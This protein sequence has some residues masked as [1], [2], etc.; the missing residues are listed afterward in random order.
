M[1]SDCL[2]DPDELAISVNSLDC[3]HPRDREL[4]SLI[5]RV[6]NTR[7]LFQPNVCNLSFPGDLSAVRSEVSAR[8]VD[9]KWTVIEAA[10]NK[11]ILKG[12]Y[13]HAAQLVTNH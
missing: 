6:R 9:C 1:L 10:G 7:N 3:G 13:P 4:V 11:R 2:T 8:R 5:A 12:S